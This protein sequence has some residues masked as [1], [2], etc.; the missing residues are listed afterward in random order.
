MTTTVSLM[1]LLM[2]MAL[3]GFFSIG[4][5][6]CF[7]RVYMAAFD[8]SQ[9][10]EKRLLRRVELWLL[11]SGLALILHFGAMYALTGDTALFFHNWALFL[12]TTPIVY[13]GFGKL[14][15]TLQAVVIAVL[16]EAHHA[17]NLL[18]P[19]TVTAMLLFA[20]VLTTMAHF[21]MKLVNHWLLGVVGSAVLAALFWSSAPTQ[22]ML[23]TLT[24]DQRQWAIGM[25]AIMAFVVFGY[26]LRAYAD[27]LNKASLKRLVEYD[28]G[29]SA[30]AYAQYQKAL[31][32]MFNAASVHHEPLTLLSIDCDHFKQINDRYGHLAA[33][34]ALIGVSD[35]IHQTLEQQALTYR[36]YQTGGE[37]L[38]VVFPGVHPQ[39]VVQIANHI[40]QAVK[41]SEYTYDGRSMNGTVSIGI[42]ERHDDD[43][44]I[45]ELY[46]R[47]DDAVYTSKRNGRDLITVEHT[48]LTDTAPAVENYS[49]YRYFA[50]GVYDLSL[51]GQPRY[52]HELLLR[53][54]DAEQQR[55][56]LPND[57]EIPVAEIPRLLRQVIAADPLHNYNINLTAAQFRDVEV[58][59]V[60]TALAESPDGPTNLTVEVTEVANAAITRHIS[61]IYR[62]A[63]MKILIDDVGSDNSFELVQNELPYF[64]GVKFAM[65]NLRRTNDADQ[66][67]ERIAFWRQVAKSNH[68]SFILEGVETQADLELA[69]TLGIQ[70]V[71]GYFFDKP[72]N[73]VPAIA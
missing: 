73:L 53:H 42:T 41:D 48:V 58:A 69:Q 49:Q 7:Q 70:F 1:N 10:R 68:L 18:E 64:D 9:R 50:Q 27:D 65:Q 61:A 52:Y 34:A 60:L 72:E 54:Y 3:V 17:S 38:N 51:D 14:E 46:K 45:D 39:A 33:N 15:I 37:E 31:T 21:R 2:R 44:S 59:R 71:Q 66:M 67:R 19:T 63:G 12:A 56:V 55:W 36:I 16:W 43:Q 20:A 13:A 11:S 40:R 47:A 22:S 24:T 30:Q 23:I 5:I 29:A 62:S 32:S 8:Q 4:F 25:Y 35:T 57:F 28:A 6:A 26:W